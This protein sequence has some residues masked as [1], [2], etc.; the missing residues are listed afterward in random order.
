QAEPASP[1]KVNRVRKGRELCRKKGIDYPVDLWYQL[2]YYVY[3]ESVSVFSR[4]CKSTNQIVC[5]VAFWKNLY[6]RFYNKE[7]K[8]PKTLQPLCLERIHSLQPN[9][10]RAL[11]HFYQPFIDR[12]NPASTF[13]AEP[14]KLIGRRCLLYWYQPVKN[15]WNF[16][17]KLV[18]PGMSCRTVCKN[19]RTYIDNYDDIFYNVEEGCTILQVTCS[20][21]LSLPIA[22]GQILNH[23]HL[24]VSG[25]GFRYHT[26]RLVFDTRYQ[27]NRDAVGTTVVLDSVVNIKVIPWW[28]PKYP[29]SS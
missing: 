16:C 18:R 28:D 5:T 1:R 29:F 13:E 8:L 7:I 12:L 25:Q 9:V 6:Q 2:S 23:V 10:V 4:L 15:M 22:M 17:F 14:H 26:L 20:H 11:Y 24:T 21:F 3:P 19:Q 27:H